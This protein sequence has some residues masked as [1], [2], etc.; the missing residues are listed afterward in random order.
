MNASILCEHPKKYRDKRTGETRYAPCRQCALCRQQQRNDHITAIQLEIAI[1]PCVL[2]ATRTCA[3]DHYPKNRT[4]IDRQHRHYRRNLQKHGITR[5]LTQEERG[6]TTARFHNH[7]LVFINDGR[8]HFEIEQIIRKA[9]P[10]GHVDVKLGTHQKAVYLGSHFTKDARDKDKMHFHPDGLGALKLHWLRFPAVGC[11]IIPNLAREY[12]TQPRHRA[13]LA[14]MRDV[15]PNVK[16]SGR[17]RRLPYRVK[18]KLRA[19][20]GMESSD[21]HRDQ[22]QRIRVEEAAADQLYTAKA[23][24]KRLA[25]A[26]RSHHLEVQ[27]QARARKRDP[28]LAIAE[29]R[30]AKAVA[31]KTYM[32]RAERRRLNRKLGMNI[33]EVGKYPNRPQRRREG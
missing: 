6:E 23:D 18:T 27:E 19:E 7:D 15:Y 11:S 14:L 33:G 29:E 2:F 28:G 30:Y 10:Y 31:D 26:Q 22:I 17:N 25:K 9:W 20:L 4:D 1:T 8:T 16:V 12:M 3:P 24:K 5:V 21:P 13:Q 32:P